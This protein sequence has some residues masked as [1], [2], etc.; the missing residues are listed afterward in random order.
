MLVFQECEE[1]LYTLCIHTAS[2]VHTLYVPGRV[3]PYF[4]VLRAF[5]FSVFGLHSEKLHALQIKLFKAYFFAFFGYN[6]LCSTYKIHDNT[7]NYLLNTGLIVIWKINH[8][9]KLKIFVWFYK[10][11]RAHF[12]CCDR[13]G[14]EKRALSVR[15]WRSVKLFKLIFK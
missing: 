6:F 4:F 12:Y 9:G 10:C 2:Y 14:Y 11:V 8:Y 7:K 13:Y 5:Q 1:S 15:T 3:G